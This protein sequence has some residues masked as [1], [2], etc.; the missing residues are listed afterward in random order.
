MM[1]NALIAFLVV[2]N[3]GWATIVFAQVA[4]ADREPKFNYI[5][6]VGWCK[7]YGYQGVFVIEGKDCAIAA[8]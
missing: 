4:F 7:V 5:G 8:R 6:K 2:M 1:K 3:I